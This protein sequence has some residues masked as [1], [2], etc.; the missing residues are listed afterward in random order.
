M[1]YQ[2]KYIVDADEH[3]WVL[4]RNCAMTPRQLGAWFGSLA[5]LSLLLA[6]AL[7]LR[8]AWL[9]VPFTMIE[10]VALGATFVWWGRHAGDCERIVVGAGVFRL[11]TSDGGH[12]HQV[13]GCSTLARVRYGGSRREL[14]RIVLKGDEIAIGQYVP[15]DRR[16]ALAK[17]LSGVLASQWAVERPCG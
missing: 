17:E 2:W 14:I 12:L 13:E 11:E 16:A 3:E 9:V 7:A 10:I 15:D 1:Q 5:L 6:T 4:K 8:G